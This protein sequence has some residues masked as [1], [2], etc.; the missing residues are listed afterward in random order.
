L[1]VIPDAAKRRSGIQKLG[2]TVLLDSGLR[3]S[4]GPGMMLNF[5]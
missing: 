2:K 3:P 1:A 5:Q 4:V